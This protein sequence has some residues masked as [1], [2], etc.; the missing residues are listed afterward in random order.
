MGSKKCVEWGFVYGEPEYEVSF[1]LA[2]RDGDYRLPFL[3]HRSLLTLRNGPGT[4]NGVQIRAPRKIGIGVS[5]LGV[6]R[7][8]FT[9]IKGQWLN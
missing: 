8:V 3:K 4:R 6:P 5:K 2:L 1:G 9:E 7:H